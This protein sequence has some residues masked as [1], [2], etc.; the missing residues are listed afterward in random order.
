MGHRSG[1]KVSVPCL[2]I[3]LTWPL[4]LVPTCLK[5]TEKERVFGGGLYPSCRGAILYEGN[6]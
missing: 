1:R 4:S 6:P 3:L 2:L 5:S